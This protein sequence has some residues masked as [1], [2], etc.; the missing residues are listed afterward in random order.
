MRLPLACLCL[1]VAACA[2]PAPRTPASSDWEAIVAAGYEVPEGQS[3]YELLVQLGEYFG[4]PDPHLRDD[5]GYGISAHWIVR[6]KLCDGNELAELSQRWRAGLEPGLGSAGDELA[7]RRSF[8]ALALSLIAAR[9]A[10]DALLPEGEL[11]ALTDDSIAWFERERDTRAFDPQLGWVHAT[12]HGADLLKFLAR[13]PRNGPAELARILDA[14]ALRCARPEDAAWTAGEDERIAR[15]LAAVALRA[16]LDPQRLER[17]LESLLAVAARARTAVVVEPRAL[18]AEQN[19]V[20]VLRTLHA[21]LSTAENL[22]THAVIAA[23]AVRRAT[24]RL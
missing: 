7:L 12:A 20:H 15:A 8:S 14:I 21:L 13:N 18:A 10:A 17:F 24:A 11:R 5:L 22:P 6:R 1:F 23:D 3:P 9:D 16:E 4:S 2:A 19:A